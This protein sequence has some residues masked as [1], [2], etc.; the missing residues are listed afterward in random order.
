MGLHPTAA[1]APPAPTSLAS[2]T[3]LL[4]VRNP[5]H[6]HRVELGAGSVCSITREGSWSKGQGHRALGS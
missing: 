6:R 3:F 5:E 2:L 1:T 4:C